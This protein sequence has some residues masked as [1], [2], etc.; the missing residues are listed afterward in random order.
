MEKIC[1]CFGEGSDLSTIFR[2]N[3]FCP[4]CHITGLVKG[5]ARP[6]AHDVHC[7]FV[8]FF[9]CQKIIVSV[10]LCFPLVQR[11]EYQGLC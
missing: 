5:T 4:Y 10:N 11:V 8:V 1:I 7:Y 2:R 9:I 6:V 3:V